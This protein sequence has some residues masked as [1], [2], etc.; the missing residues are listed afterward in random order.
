MRVNLRIDFL[1]DGTDNTDFSCHESLV[2]LKRELRL[3]VGLCCFC[4]LEEFHEVVVFF[5][6]GIIL[7]CV[8]EAVD[9]REQVLVLGLLVEVDEE[10]E[11][12]PPNLRLTTD[13]GQRTTVVGLGVENWCLGGLCGFCQ[14]GQKFVGGFDCAS[15]EGFVA[16]A[17][18]EE[19]EDG[20]Q[21]FCFFFE[22]EGFSMGVK[23]LEEGLDGMLCLVP[24][25]LIVLNAVVF[26]GVE[27]EQLAVGLE[28]KGGHWGIEN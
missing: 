24:T 1:T 17:N 18:L 6:H 16:I 21:D 28:A 22:G 14:L 3:H 20:E 4:E 2:G 12:A 15:E 10:G 27:E 8:H 5:G 26:E 19:D 25:G 11:L 23:A 7:P 13:D 9:G